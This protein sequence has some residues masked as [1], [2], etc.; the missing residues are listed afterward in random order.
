[1]V[2]EPLIAPE[3]EAPAP[4]ADEPPTMLAVKPGVDGITLPP[5]GRVSVLE[6]TPELL[7]LEAVV[8]LVI[9]T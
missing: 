5:V 2:A 9:G 1:M 4:V 3:V 6:P 8:P 7:V